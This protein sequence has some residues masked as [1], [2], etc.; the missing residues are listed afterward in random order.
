MSTHELE[1]KCR[2]L[3][4]L[5]APIDEGQAEAEAIQDPLKAQHTRPG[6][7]ELTAGGD[8]EG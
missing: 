1:I 7:D 6:G 5:Q 3:R 8:K 2:E 4:Q